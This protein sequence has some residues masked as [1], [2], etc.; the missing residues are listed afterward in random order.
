MAYWLMKSEPDV[1]GIEHL[2]KAPGQ[3]TSWDGVRNYQVR[4][5]LRDDIRKGDQAFFYHSGCAIPGIAGIINIVSAGHPDESAFDKQSE[6]YDAKSTRDKPTWY[7]VDVSFQKRFDK[8][9][10]LAEL[11]AEKSLKSMKLLQRGNRLSITPVSATEW[12]HILKMAR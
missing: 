8:L 12:S 10:T 2:A 7:S 11:R 6:Y 3:A 4:N 1:F 5:M 9:I